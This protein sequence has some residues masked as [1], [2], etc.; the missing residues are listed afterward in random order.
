M[1]RNLARRIIP[2]LPCTGGRAWRRVLPLAA[3]LAALLP[4]WA[5]S[6]W[7]MM[8][9]DIY[10]TGQSTLTVP[11][12][13]PPVKWTT[14]LGSALR[15]TPA[16][17]PGDGQAVVG[18][19]DGRLVW[20]D[21]ADGSIVRTMNAAARTP[22][23]GTPLVAPDGAVYAANRDGR[24]YYRTAGGVESHV[25]INTDP[26][27][28]KRF[29]WGPLVAS[30]MLLTIGGTDYVL[31]ASTDGSLYL[32]ST[33]DFSWVQ[34]YTAN[35]P[36]EST[37][38][39][40]TAMPV[41]SATLT[42]A[43]TAGDQLVR[44]A[45]IDQTKFAPGDELS[46][47][48]GVNPVENLGFI[49]RMYIDPG[50]PAKWIL[51]I[52][53]TAGTHIAGAT[54]TSTTHQPLFFGCNDGRVYAVNADM[55]PATRL[56][57]AFPGAGTRMQGFLA[58]PLVQGMTVY[59]GDRA[60]LFYILEARLGT[61][62]NGPYA[63][64]GVTG[65]F[66]TAARSDANTLFAGSG[67]GLVRI[68]LLN[69]LDPL[70]IIAGVAGPVY[71]QPV[72]DTAGQV[73]SGTQG[74]EVYCITPAGGLA[75]PGPALAGRGA[76]IYAST[77]LAQD[78]TVLATTTDGYVICLQAG[79]TG[80]TPGVGSIPGGYWPQYQRNDIHSGSLEGAS[81]AQYTAPTTLNS[82]TASYFDAT[83]L[84]WAVNT[85]GAVGS[86]VA[87]TRNGDTIRK[88][89]LA[90][91]STIGSATLVVYDAGNLYVGDILLLGDEYLGPITAITRAAGND[92]LTVTY[93][94]E[95]AH[96]VNDEV[97]VSL[98]RRD[99][100]AAAA[101]G[102]TNQLRVE[103][104]ERFLAGD[105]LR[106]GAKIVTVTAINSDLLTIAP[107]LIIGESYAAGTLVWVGQP[108]EWAAYFG[109]D[110]GWLRAVNPDNGVPY[111]R[112]NA[113]YYLGS[114]RG[115]PLVDDVLGRV[116]VTSAGGRLFAFAQNG[117]FLWAYP[118]LGTTAAGAILGSPVLADHLDHDGVAQRYIYCAT[119]DGVVYELTA[120][121]E[122]ATSS[123]DG[124]TPCR[125]PATGALSPIVGGLAL[126]RAANDKNAAN[127]RVIFGARNGKVYALDGNLNR[128]WTY[129]DDVPAPY[130]PT[131]G[132]LSASPIVGPGDPA[133]GATDIIYIGDTAGKVHAI[134]EY[135]DGTGAIKVWS[136]WMANPPADRTPIQYNAGSAVRV[137]AAVAQGSVV[138]VGD[139]SG[140]MHAITGSTTATLNGQV[141]NLDG[142]VTGP[143]TMDAAGNLLVGTAKGSVYCMPPL[144]EWAIPRNFGATTQ[145]VPA[146]TP[147]GGM[148][149]N[150]T[151]S[152]NPNGQTVTL[153]GRV[154][155]GF[156]DD[157]GA[158]LTTYRALA[159]PGGQ[160]VALGF[161]ETDAAIGALATPECYVH[162]FLTDT[163][164]VGLRRQAPG[165][166]D[167]AE[168]LT[169]AAI[170]LA[171]G[172][173]L[174]DGVE[175]MITV[176]S[177]GLAT[178]YYRAADAD[179]RFSGSFVSIGTYALPAA[180]DA[181]I[182]T[183]MHPFLQGFDL[184]APQP[185]FTARGEQIAA[186]FSTPPTGL[187]T[188]GPFF[189]WVWNS[190]TH[191]GKPQ[192]LPIRTASALWMGD[193]VMVGC[194]DGT[195]Y[196]IG[197][198]GP[199]WDAT[200]Q[201]TPDLAQAGGPWPFFQRDS[202]RLGS[203]NL[204]SPILA[205]PLQPTLRWFATHTQPVEGTPTVTDL[206]P[207]RTTRVYVG[208]EEGTVYAN[209]AST[210]VEIWNRPLAGG[211]PVRS[212]P[213][214]NSNGNIA[215][216][217]MDGRVYD[218]TSAGLVNWST[219]DP[220]PAPNRLLGCFAASPVR[221]TDG[222]VYAAS[223]DELHITG[224]YS[225][226]V[227][228]AMTDGNPATDVNGQN[229]ITYELG[230][231]TT[232]SRV[233]IRTQNKG[234]LHLT[235]KDNNNVDVEVF[236]GSFDE[237]PAPRYITVDLNR[238][239]T[240]VRWHNLS[241]AAVAVQAF[242]VYTVGAL[243]T[244]TALLTFLDDTGAPVVF[245]GYMG[246]TLVA[247]LTT[248]PANI[249]K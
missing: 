77:I 224:T 50:D 194:D 102:P 149:S 49:T 186:Y 80:A 8:G 75:W 199:Q 9:H 125:Y 117:Q 54:I 184:T 176:Q 83:K 225:P 227:L 231:V 167:A 161:Q 2:L 185:G 13:T 190:V 29:P 30:P 66:T 170:P 122:L 92:T 132:V 131:V 192:G 163:G 43:T 247:D 154:I 36:I 126:Y 95:A 86:S 60:G 228:A 189:R 153:V 58:S 175:V 200:E 203:L 19:G 79:G 31:V 141:C 128:V 93:A 204:F 150:A 138:Y 109:S 202:E 39:L 6:N 145:V 124:T 191:G 106:L 82:S 240:R 230:A 179:G 140:R 217:A 46:L 181:G 98:Y 155:P 146:N 113:G 89:V 17:I 218:L 104:P 34:W 7:P 143:A 219:L 12:P 67:G 120:D 234:E 48:D 226:N 164:Q 44:I 201:P 212:A 137:A 127:L 129:P 133:I 183:A 134:Y 100:L 216:T 18:T 114:V 144:G 72:T 16:M 61:L 229:D 232:V 205:G 180:G 215:V 107:S 221:S 62:Q 73:L 38:A 239:V 136:A 4:A 111:W 56:R 108:G 96:N 119:E 151:V 69:L 178:A 198:R 28:S 243:K 110:D 112:N 25:P 208:T 177:G 248:K 10:H 68:N 55:Q 162:V 188:A 148:W 24:L 135:I 197:P 118:A 196:A 195:L 59:I 23:S 1:H 207:D 57:W 45:T 222:T 32:V 87:V 139:S 88:A 27:P 84:R 172:R 147:N 21:M 241:T 171:P 26:D 51:E 211:G 74:G 160:R 78:Q 173:T 220:A 85:G 33:A 159:D 193:L 187:D 233:R 235:V 213:S 94:P 121:G 65:P 63:K 40:G 3:L 214:V 242:E 105:Q 99:A 157:A 5:Q 101:T 15:C 246:S 152:Y 223:V 47:N 64:S 37:P 53:G 11:V 206:T 158:P 182:A 76:P 236:Y 81:N 103:H 166:A 156:T 174:A 123:V 116:Y 91:A 249:W 244:T 165:T 41:D 169:P 20:L 142:A 90:Q 238:D 42:D 52:S 209:N 168:V 210:G 14:A 70:G 35:G 22:F 115:A 97:A 71:E 245:P 130:T 237:A